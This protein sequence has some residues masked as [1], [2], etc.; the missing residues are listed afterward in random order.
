MITCIIQNLPFDNPDKSILNNNRK[1]KP[2]EK[3]S[4]ISQVS[5]FGQQ[6]TKD[7]E[8][9]DE[10]RSDM[11][12]GVYA[13]AQK[14]GVVD[15]RAVGLERWLRKEEVRLWVHCVEESVDGFHVY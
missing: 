3:I 11:D 9:V 5:K 4:H 2:G 1:V 7:C 10:E 15:G 6:R 14:D 12:E 8:V 13:D